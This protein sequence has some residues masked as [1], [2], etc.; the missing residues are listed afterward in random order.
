MP[1]PLKSLF[2]GESALLLGNGINLAKQGITWEVLLKSLID[3]FG[4]QSEITVNENRTYPL[5]VEELLFSLSG[6]FNDNLK[7]LRG[8]VA[9]MVGKYGPGPLHVT[10]LDTK[11]R[12]ILTTNYDYAL[13]RVIDDEFRGPANPGH[14]GEYKYSLRRCNTVNGISVW[15]INGELNNGF[16]PGA[17]R[18]AEESILIGHEHYADYLRQLHGAL[19][20]GPGH[21]GLSNVLSTREDLWA[22]RFFTH[23]VH[24]I[25]YTLDYSEIHLWWLLNFRARLIRTGSSVAN[26]IFYFFG[27]FQQA[28]LAH[29]LALLKAL[30]VQVIEV[31]TKSTGDRYVQL[32]EGALSRVR[33][34]NS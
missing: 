19:K 20:P 13:E 2:S 23:D 30:E 5:I 15:H 27:D 34:R 18:Y 8:R 3:S 31:P 12:H 32:Y 16:K 7:L 24:I 9:S 10:A 4:M 6:R 22:T 1:L 29:R 26:R 28:D 33:T 14:S 25:G 11:V 17:R 21:G